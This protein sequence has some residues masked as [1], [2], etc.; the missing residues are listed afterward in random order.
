[1][2]LGYSHQKKWAGFSVVEVLVGIVLVALLVSLLLPAV[3]RVRETGRRLSCQNNLKQIGLA[4]AQFA[5]V[6]RDRLPP[7]RI[8]KGN[9]KTVSWSSFFLQFMD[10]VARQATWEPVIDPELIYE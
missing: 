1:M 9:F 10:D 2:F 5:A 8:Q 4:T 7:G 6:H 3:Q